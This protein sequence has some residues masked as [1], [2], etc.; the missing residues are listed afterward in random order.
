M[1]QDDISLETVIILDSLLGFIP[2]ESKK[3]SDT[4]IW[5][6]IKRRIEKYKPFVNF[7]DIKC[8]NLLL[9][10]FTNNA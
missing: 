2:R 7:D 9:K 6:D 10:G 3:I 8:R 1:M 4:I 5:P